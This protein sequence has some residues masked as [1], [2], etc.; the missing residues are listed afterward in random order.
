MRS[1]HR[2]IQAQTCALALVVLFASSAAQAADGTPGAAGTWLSIAPPVTAI[3]I[4]LVLRQVIPALF[5]GVWLGAWAINGFSLYGLWT[6]LLDAFEVH[7]GITKIGKK[8]VNYQAEIVR[9]TELIACGHTT[10]VCCT[11]DSDGHMTSIDV[12]DDVTNKLKKY[13]IPTTERVNSHD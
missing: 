3:L 6:G 11:I 1:G 9:D 2:S 5:A 4:A 13:L 8:S 12:P 10:S 7:I